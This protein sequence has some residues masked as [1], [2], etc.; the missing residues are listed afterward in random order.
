MR[1]ISQ[2][3]LRAHNGDG[4]SRLWVAQA[5]M[6]YDVT[7]FPK[8]R[9]GMHE[10]IHFPG[11]DLSSELPEAPHGQEVFDRPCVKIVG[12]LIVE[13]GSEVGNEHC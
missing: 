3:E 7:D 13:P 5:G 1:A 4:G 8:W 12:R 10:Q 6:V 11:L 2:A 9:T